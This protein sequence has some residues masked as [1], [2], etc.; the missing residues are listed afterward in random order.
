MRTNDDGENGAKY[1]NAMTAEMSSWYAISTSLCVTFWPKNLLRATCVL[2]TMKYLRPAKPPHPYPV[3]AS[4]NHSWL[5]RGR[6]PKMNSYEMPWFFDRIILYTNNAFFI[7]AVV[8]IGMSFFEGVILL[9]S[10]DKKGRPNGD[11]YA[12]YVKLPTSFSRVFCVT[13]ADS[14]TLSIRFIYFV[15]FLSDKRHDRVMASYINPRISIFLAGGQHFLKFILA[16]VSSPTAISCLNNKFARILSKFSPLF[17]FTGPPKKSSTYDFKIIGIWNFSWIRSVN[18][19]HHA[20]VQRQK[21]LD[22]LALPNG[23]LRSI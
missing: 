13:Y 4:I 1:M 5:A 7:D 14:N 22:E 3:E 19:P 20:V 10:T 17:D 8:K 21:I 15:R 9:D 18:A 16:P 12:A 11:T 2:F 6:R 23:I